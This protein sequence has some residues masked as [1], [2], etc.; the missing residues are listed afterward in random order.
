MQQ[1]CGPFIRPFCQCLT[2]LDPSQAERGD[3]TFPTGSCQTR[4][5]CFLPKFSQDKHTHIGPYVCLIT[6]FRLGVCDQ[7]VAV[8]GPELLS[9]H[10]LPLQLLQRDVQAVKN[11][12]VSAEFRGEFIMNMS[13]VEAEKKTRPV[14]PKNPTTT[15]VSAL[16]EKI[17]RGGWYGSNVSLQSYQAS[18]R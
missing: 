15:A 12:C 13:H 17:Y 10:D 7:Q 1:E 4:T 6:F 18:W 9:A 2:F 3:A 8:P 14:L 5:T 16:L 11:H